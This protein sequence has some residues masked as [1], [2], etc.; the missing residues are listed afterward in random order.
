M[1]SGGDYPPAVMNQSTPKARKQHTCCECGLPIPVGAKYVY[2]WGIWDGTPDVYK[3]HV[4]CHELLDFISKNFCDNEP[5]TFGS[6]RDEVGEYSAE[7]TAMLT[8]IEE[9]YRPAVSA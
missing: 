6:L 9:K 1:C 8:A 7:L 3:Q 4:E 5:W 2:T